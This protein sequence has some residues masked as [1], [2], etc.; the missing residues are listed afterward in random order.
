M[1]SLVAAVGSVEETHGGRYR[2]SVGDEIEVVDRPRDED[3]DVQMVLDLRR[4][5]TSAGYDA[6]V[7]QMAAEGKE[8]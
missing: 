5:L 2:I 6:V 7:E 1:T 3:V 4:L 8:D